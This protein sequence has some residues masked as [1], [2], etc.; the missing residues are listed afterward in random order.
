MHDC[1][2]RLRH[3][4]RSSYAV[5]QQINIV[6][7]HVD[8]KGHMKHALCWLPWKPQLWAWL[9]VPIN[10]KYANIETM[11]SN[12]EYCVVL[13]HYSLKS[14]SALLGMCTAHKIDILCMLVCE[15]GESCK[16][17]ESCESYESSES[18]ES[19][20]MGLVSLVSLLSPVSLES[21]TSQMSQVSL[22]SQASKVNPL[23]FVNQ[24]SLM[25]PNTCMLHKD[26]RQH[27]REKQYTI[28]RLEIRN[29]MQPSTCT[30]GVGSTN[31]NM[32]SFTSRHVVY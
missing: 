28:K 5:T 15:F 32:T 26:L 13:F 21:Q 12:E 2:G 3:G 22:E 20:V 23:S 7:V 30:L 11:L 9:S 25:G 14:Y 17:G 1:P 18:G 24:V 8:L 4:T 6:Y 16:P 19:C 10:I 27:G 29:P 31:L